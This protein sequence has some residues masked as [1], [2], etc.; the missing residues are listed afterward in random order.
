MRPAF[1]SAGV[2]GWEF[3]PE[4]GMLYLDE[5]CVALFGLDPQAFD[6]RVETWLSLVHP[7]DLPRVTAAV[8]TAVRTVGWLASM[9]ATSSPPGAC[10]IW[11]RR[12]NCWP[13]S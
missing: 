12:P 7:D 11:R 3:Y 5:V 10:P 13:A 1:R 2:G 6:G 8:D 9:C 4:P